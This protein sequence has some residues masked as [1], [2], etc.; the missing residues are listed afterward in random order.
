MKVLVAGFGAIVALTAVITTTLGVSNA[1]AQI[2]KPYTFQGT[3]HFKYN[4]KSASKGEEKTGS[5]T[6]DIEKIEGE[7]FKVNF[8]SKL[9]ENESS[10]STT[11]SADELPGKVMMSILM[12][13]N[14]AG[15]VLGATLFTPMLG[16]MFMGVNDFE[17]GSGWSRTEDGKKMSF[18]IEA[19]ETVGG[20]EGN[21]CVYKENDQTRYLQVISP[22]IPLPLRTEVNDEEGNRYSSELVEYRK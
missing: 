12:S 22:E 17:V 4:L 8:S 3:E 16:M 15:A 19:K 9:G 5:F 2:W 1:V 14:E 6:L 18:Q 11:A 7:K 21:R 13:G 20:F 10:S